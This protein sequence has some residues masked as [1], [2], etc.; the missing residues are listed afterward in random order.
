MI[1]N[2][3]ITEHYRIMVLYD[4]KYGNK[5]ICTIYIDSTGFLFQMSKFTNTQMAT[6]PLRTSAE[7]DMKILWGI[8]NNQAGMV[9]K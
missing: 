2:Q 9:N 5:I 3:F 1:L 7:S 6:L 8:E 4:L